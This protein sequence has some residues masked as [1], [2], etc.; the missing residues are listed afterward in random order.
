[1][2]TGDGR[3]GSTALI[4]VLLM[5]TLL[6]SAPAHSDVY[7]SQAG[8][9]N[10][11]GSS[12]HPYQVVEQGIYKVSSGGRV[13]MLPGTYSEAMVVSKPCELHALTTEVR[14][15]GLDG[16][17]GAR[18]NILTLNC[19]LFGPLG[20]PPLDPY[21][22]DWYPYWNDAERAEDI[23][24]A[25]SWV[26]PWAD[27]IGLQEVWHEYPYQS[28]L[29][30]SIY[31]YG[32]Y[33]SL[34]CAPDGDD[35]NSGLALL[36][37]YSPLGNPEQQCWDACYSAQCEAS[38][39]WLRASLHKS[40]FPITVFTLHTQAFNTEGDREA[41]AAQIAEI[42]QEVKAWRE[43]CPSD[44]VFVVGDFN[45]IGGS[46]E[47]RSALVGRLGFG[48]LGGK[49]TDADGAATYCHDNPLAVYI[50]NNWAPYD[51]WPDSGHLRLDYIFCFPSRNGSHGV[52]PVNVE[53]VPIRGRELS[54][55]GLTTD[56]KSDH[57]AVRGEF[58]LVSK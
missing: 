14:I 50:A 34:V 4:L 22:Y 16:N 5:G 44:V 31:G 29:S 57:W 37:L 19:C 49:D 21:P 56:E 20:I 46:Y 7:V 9:S 23:G 3:R 11:D 33:G 53:V 47:Y 30:H 58:K 41:R 40:G 35:F 36:S 54:G 48:G 8:S 45:V 51:P 55:D 12:S 2:S 26:E 43:A 10:P 32:L 18:F 24:N 25:V 39:G 42:T 17:A 38:K 6:I 15:G 1:M 13:I 27:V 52:I 28:I